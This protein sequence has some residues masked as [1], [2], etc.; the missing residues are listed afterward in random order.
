MQAEFSFVAVSVATQLYQ[1]A[2]AQTKQVYSWHFFAVQ[3]SQHHY[4]LVRLSQETVLIIIIRMMMMIMMIMIIALKGA[5]RDFYNLLTA[6]RTVS[7]AYALVARAQSCANHVQHIERSSR[8][9]WSVSLGTKGR[10][11]GNRSTRRK[12]L[13]TSFRK[14]HILKPENSSLKRDS[15]PHSSTDGRLGKQG[16]VLWRPTIVKWR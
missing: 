14:C 11:G 6:P 15:N 7:N 8:A 16:P 13:T 4:Y 12:P 2:N 1:S 5:I 9:T 10:R 3:S